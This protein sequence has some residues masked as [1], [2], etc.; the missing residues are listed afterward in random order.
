M[1]KALYQLTGKGN[2][3]EVTINE[4]DQWVAS[5]PYFAPAQFLL[6]AKLKQ[7]EHPAFLKQVQKAAV[8]FNNPFWMHYQLMEEHQQKTFAKQTADEETKPL[9]QHVVEEELQQQQFRVNPIEIPTMERVQDMMREI[10]QQ[11]EIVI[12]QVVDAE[13]VAETINETAIEEIPE[14]VIAPII[15][16]EEMALPKAIETV[17][18]AEESEKSLNNMEETVVE[19][20]GENTKSI[21]DFAKMEL[22]EDGIVEEIIEVEDAEQDPHAN[23]IASLLGEQLAAF[24]KPVEADSALPIDTDPYHTVDYFASQGIKVE[25][26]NQSQDQLSRHLRRFTDWLKHMKNMQP[27][28]EDLGTDPELESAIQG[29]A[30]TSNEAKEIVTETMAEVLEKQGKKDKAIQL[31]IKLSFLNPDKSAYFAS[32]IQQLKGI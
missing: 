10:D 19:F 22:S 9:L 15:G 31:Y 13:T 26:D 25:Q 23:K 4:L 12:E 18:A 2:F 21:Q 6:A 8:F 3:K 27:N 7:E 28:P 20:G 14:A 17:E 1:D 5:Y 29:I 24:Q 30:S 11:D 32:R 16:E